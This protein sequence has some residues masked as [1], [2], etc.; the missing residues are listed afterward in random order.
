MPNIHPELIVFLI[1][2]GSWVVRALKPAIEK[3]RAKAAQRKAAEDA[4]RSVVYD[5]SSPT[6][7]VAPAELSQQPVPASRFEEATRQRTNRPQVSTDPAVLERRR[8]ALEELRRR[9]ITPPARPA[10]RQTAA[11]PVRPQ[12]PQVPQVPQQPLLRKP[13]PPRRPQ[14]PR[15]APARPP[16]SRPAPRESQVSPV[17]V[18]QTVHA[19]P[20]V[21]PLTGR[22][23]QP[24][25]VSVAHPGAL[26]GRSISATDLRRALVMKEILDPPLALRNMSASDLTDPF[27]F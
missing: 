4:V 15:I 23:H 7:P 11:Q 6:Q 25:A 17:A 24:R 27:T 10:P 12:V 1:I 19:P 20:Q 13:A 5:N 26:L 22:P 18:P 14:P 8:A 3:A 9:A 16:K 21:Q 2:V